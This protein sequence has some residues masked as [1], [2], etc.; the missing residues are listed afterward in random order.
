MHIGKLNYK[1]VFDKYDITHV[2]LDKDEIM[3]QYIV[4]D[5]EWEIIYD[6]GQFSLYEKVID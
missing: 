2:L 6:T 3:N 4:Y 1:E 5:D